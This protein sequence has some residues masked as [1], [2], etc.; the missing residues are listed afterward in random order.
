MRSPA[1][2]LALT[3]CA[4]LTTLAW[5][6]RPFTVDI[7]AADVQRMTFLAS[8]ARFPQ[9]PEFVGGNATYGVELDVIESI[10]DQWVHDFNW[11]ERREYLNSF[12]QF[13]VKIEDVDVHFVHQRS[14]DAGAI[15]LL[16]L[17]GWP[18]S[19]HE[20]LPAGKAV[21]PSLPG[22][23]FTPLPSVDWKIDD[24]AR[25]FNTLMVDVLG[26]SDYTV[27]G[28]DWGS[29]V[30]Y[31]L[32]VD[33]ASAVRATQLSFLPFF[34]PTL[35]E[36]R[37]ANASLDAFEVATLALNDEFVSRGMGYFPRAIMEDPRRGTGPSVLTN[38]AILTEIL[39]YYLTKSFLSS[40]W[41]YLQQTFSP[42]YDVPKPSTPLGYSA[43]RYNII[44]PRAYVEKVANVTFYNEHDFGGHFPGLDN[45]TALAA[46]IREMFGYFVRK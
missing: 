4:A 5:D 28:G 31:V 42:S 33:Y 2:L 44:W 41:I 11:T 37:S 22:F 35:A 15:P 24:T 1:L 12:A 43:F 20:Y 8:E 19:F 18:G 32:Y 34:P 16:M 23:G 21:I 45:P 25:V 38:T 7:P 27:Y 6:V 46:D 29:A 36:A 17:H 40:I 9:L 13:T 10:R 30:G 3:G 14:D 26:Y 39:L